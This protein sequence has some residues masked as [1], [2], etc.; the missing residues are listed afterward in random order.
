MVLGQG[1]T[2]R[3]QPEGQCA[4]A[5]GWRPERDLPPPFGSQNPRTLG[6]LAFFLLNT[7]FRIIIKAGSLEPGVGAPVGRISL[8]SNA[9][10]EGTRRISVTFRLA[11]GTDSH[12]LT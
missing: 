8:E 7:I 9:A 12:P 3:K 1:P 5:E 6:T 2:V 4:R 10:A 11:P